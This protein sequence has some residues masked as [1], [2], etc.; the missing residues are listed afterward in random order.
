MYP[1]AGTLFGLVRSVRVA[2][3]A[4]RS[5]S[6][7]VY[8]RRRLGASVLGG[9]WRLTPL[10][11]LPPFSVVRAAL[12]LGA[13]LLVYVSCAPPP[14]L[15]LCRRKR[16]VRAL[17]PRGSPARPSASLAFPPRA[18]P[19]LRRCARVC[20]RRRVLLWFSGC[21]RARPLRG[22]KP[23]LAPSSVRGCRVVPLPLAPAKPGFRRLL[24]AAGAL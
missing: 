6:F 11:P 7:T 21:L 9:A 19:S 1:P 23:P 4:A 16:V 18:C 2:P 5:F 17:S 10:S 8:V 14:R 15:A 24:P 20:A 22:G 12:R 13:V 3:R